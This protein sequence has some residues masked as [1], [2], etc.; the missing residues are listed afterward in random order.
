MK[1]TRR[2]NTLYFDPEAWALIK[3]AAKREHKSPKTIANEALKRGFKYAKRKEA[4][5]S[6]Q[7]PRSRR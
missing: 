5:E 7:I 2:K 6:S 3:Q 4:L 1:V